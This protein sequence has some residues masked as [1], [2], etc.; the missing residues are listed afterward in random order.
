MILKTVLGDT[1]VSGEFPRRRMN[2]SVAVRSICAVSA[3][4]WTVA[5]QREVRLKF[6][7]V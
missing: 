6:C 4:I 3:V 5:R 7:M 2:I 1:E